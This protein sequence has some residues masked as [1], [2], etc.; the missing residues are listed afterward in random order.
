MPGNFLKS[1]A[2]LSMLLEF[3]VLF[4]HFRLHKFIEI[5]FFQIKKSGLFFIKI[6]L[7]FSRRAVSVLFNQDFGDVG[8]L[9][10]FFVFIFTVNEHDDIRVLFN[11]AGISQV[12]E[13][14]TAATRLNR[15]RKLGERKHWYL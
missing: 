5:A 6:Q 12:G 7:N 9:S 15:A 1:S 13:T 3:I 8:L 2:N 14:R 4:A 11:G 10:L